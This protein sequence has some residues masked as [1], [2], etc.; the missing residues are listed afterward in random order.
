MRAP[1]LFN[2]FPGLRPF[3]PD[4]EH[5]FFGRE[6]EIDEL[7]RRLRCSRF[8]SVVGTSGCGKSS[9]VR[10]GLIPALQGG[11]MAKAGSSWRISVIRPGADP[12]RNLAASLNAPDVLGTNGELAKTNQLLLEVTLRRSSLGL[13]ETVRQARIPSEDNLLLVVDQF[14]ELFRFR[15]SQHIENSRDEAVAFVKLLLGAIEQK[16]VPIY[17]V[18]TMRSDFI[19]DCIEY[20]GL[21]EA[22]NAGLYLVPRMTR[23][24]VRRVITGPVAVGGGEI[25]ERL[26]SRL[27]NDLGDD[28][29]Q[30]PVLQHALLRTW[31]S[32]QRRQQTQV[33]IDIEDYE[34]VG[35]LRRALSRHAEEAYVQTGTDHGHQIAEKLFKVLTDTFTDPRG[36]RRPTSVQELAAI[37]EATEREVVEIVE[38]FREP[39]RCF[40]MPPRPTRLDSL[41][42]IDLSHE[43][44]MRCWTRLVTWSEEEQASAR[45]YTRLSQAAI[46]FEAGLAGLWDDPELAIGLQWRRDNQPTAAWAARY[47][48]YFIQ[49]MD[50]LDCSVKERNRV[51]AAREKE[52]KNQLRLAWAFA[53]ALGLLLSV[54][55]FSYYF[56]KM[57]T[58]RAGANLQLAKRAVDESLSSAGR[59]QARDVPD[60]P[61]VEQFRQELL[62]KAEE[63]Y[64]NF[65]AMQIN[66]GPEFQAES[67]LVH[68]KLGDIN[69][70]LEKREDAVNEYKLAIS[71][72]EE[73][74]QENPGNREYRRALAYAHNWLGETLRLWA[75]ETQNVP[76]RQSEAEQEY[77][78]ALRLQEGLHEELLQN[79]EYQQELARTYDNRGILRSDRKDLKNAELDFNEA[80][81]LL[82]HL[83]NSEPGSQTT[84]GQNPPSHDLVLVYNNLA[85]LLSGEKQQTRAEDLSEQAIRIQQEL[86]K[87]DPENWGY[88]EELAIFQDNLA[89]LALQNGR[90]EVAKQLNH[91]A[92]DSIETLA[93]P[94]RLMETE[95]AKAHMFYR[96]LG[97]SDHPEFHALYMHLGD[98]YVNLA[99]AYFRN[100]EPDA[101]GLAIQ[102]LGRIL[103][104]VAEPDRTR[105]EKLYRELQSRLQEIKNKSK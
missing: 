98:E 104:D 6:R 8:L 66:K 37:C 70:L 56:A 26:V 3:E 27:L 30:L 59:Q 45:Q 10:S 73:L 24:E 93:T 61:Q 12:I 47:D 28:P 40:L 19:G 11:F 89:F 52:R 33:P 99:T 55:L 92:L 80:T 83:A 62:N 78:S 84:V 34:A 44:L 43:S 75:E 16:E 14:E 49:A 105:L 102:S 18:L 13:I 86:I 39:G 9:L 4:E 91:A 57:E 7:L 88:R 50:F 1:V 22:V 63:F 2:P 69:R 97:S 64:S 23:D 17:V 68:S 58:A 94:P 31:D 60:P 46:G 29:N 32:W 15:R 76:E 87:Q 96:Y 95:R 54:A 38:L 82:E 103:P 100:D 20:P 74:N 36:V 67:A 101:A 41:S 90:R 5:L 77:E 35:T 81:R 42:I 85:I 51:Q 25:T 71:S 65:L 48:K 53:T 21:P 72:F 79:A